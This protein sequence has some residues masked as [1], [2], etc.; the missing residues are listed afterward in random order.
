MPTA[1]RRAPWG[2]YDFLVVKEFE[3]HFPESTLEVPQ[4]SGRVVLVWDPW[5]EE[6][7]GGA[8]GRGALGRGG[9]ACLGRGGTGP[10]FL[11]QLR[12]P[13]TSKMAGMR[14][15]PAWLEDPGQMQD[16]LSD[17]VRPRFFFTQRNSQKWAKSRTWPGQFHMAVVC[18]QTQRLINAPIGILNLVHFGDLVLLLCTTVEGRGELECSASRVVFW[19]R[20]APQG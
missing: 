9:A 10:S 4:A 14:I 12:D 1:G 3:S 5:W 11:S 16:T 18:F 6:R 2:C 13:L 7:S 17:F 8:F 19:E 15:E 20:R